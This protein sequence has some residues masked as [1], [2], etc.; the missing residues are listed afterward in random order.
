MVL[1]MLLELAQRE[2]G[3]TEKQKS[4]IKLNLF[5]LLPF[6]VAAI[7][8]ARLHCRLSFMLYVLP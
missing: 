5:M 1:R 2:M 6:L 8:L 3:I 7:A 4:L